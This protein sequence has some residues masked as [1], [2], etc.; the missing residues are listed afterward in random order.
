MEGP[1]EAPPAATGG[2]DGTPASGQRAIEAMTDERRKKRDALRVEGI[3][4]Y[5][6][7]FDRTDTAAGLRQRYGGLDPD[8]G[9]G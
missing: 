9:T 1:S 3:D 6:S 5:P 7:R 4:P 8:T 2:A